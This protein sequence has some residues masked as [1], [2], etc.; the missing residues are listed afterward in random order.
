MYTSQIH[1]IITKENREKQ[2]RGEDMKS[3]KWYKLDNIAKFYSFTNNNVPAI[4]RY[5]VTLTEEVDKDILKQAVEKTIQE[6]P[7]FYCSLKKG[8]F[9][10]YLEQANKPI[11][12]EEEKVPICDKMYHDGDDLLIRVNYYKKRINLEVSHI[13]SDGRG[14]LILFKSLIYQYLKIKYKIK[15]LT[16]EE[17]SSSYEKTENSFDKY[18]SGL[19]TKK[20]KQKKIYH[21][22]GR[23]KK[24]TTYMEYHIST[25][26]VQ[27]L[28]KK[29]KVTITTLLIAVLIQSYQQKMHELEKKKSIKIDVPVDLRK[30]FPSSTSRNFFGL[31]TIIY[32]NNKSNNLEDIIQSVDNQLKENIKKDQLAIRMNQMI[33][34]EKNII[35]RL[36][37][38]VIKDLV[39]RIVDK[40]VYNS[41]TSSVSNIG[42]ITVD[43]KIEPYIEGFNVLTTT[44]YL[45]LT[46]CSYQDDLSIG[47][48]SKY[49]S[50][51][52]IKNFCHFFSENKIEGIININEEISDE[53]M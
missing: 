28:A 26:K 15:G 41:T 49:I 21:Y 23:K 1:D 11:I 24:T 40:I 7:S 51:D 27:E 13:L 20:T 32:D 46:T 17:K 22:H 35:I 33:Y 6:F 18:Y 30:Y 38:M 50:N 4:F 10:Y 12:V 36:V 5:S 25:K 37:P 3:K 19:K 39:L 47:I 29:Q 53:E 34:L 31:I 42:K 8:I 48:S 43:K 52:I 14:S 44:K 2:E 16:S 45:Q 9:W